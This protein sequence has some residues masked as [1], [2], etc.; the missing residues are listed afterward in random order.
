MKEN[1]P[2]LTISLLISDRMDTIP[3]CLDSLSSIMEAIPSELILIDTSKN[4]QV[5]Q[6]L[7]EYTDLVYEFEWCNDFAKARNEGL[8]RA[9]GEWFMFLDDD[10]WFINAT[11]LIKFFQSGEYR[12]YG[13]AKYQVRNFKDAEFIYYDDCRLARV[14]KIEGDSHFESKI[15][16]HFEP[17]RGMCKNL[18]ALVCH[19]GY[20][21][22]SIEE[23]RK[24][25]ERNRTLL[26]DMIKKEPNKIYWW[27]QLAQEYSYAGEYEELISFCKMCLQ[28]IAELDDPYINRQRGTFYIG[29]ITGYIRTQK[30]EEC[31]N[32]AEKALRD[33]K[34]ELVLKA[35]LLLKLAEGY[36][37]L[38]KCTEAKNAILSYLELARN[39]NLN[40]TD[41]VDQQAVFLVGEAFNQ[42]SKEIA[43][44]ILICCDLLQDDVSALERYYDE[45]GWSK[46]VAYTI[47]GIEKIMVEAIWTLPY[48][49]LFTRIII[50]VFSKSNLREAFRKEILNQSNAGLNEFQEIIY[51]LASTLQEVIIGPKTVDM[52][53]KNAL[54]QYVVAVYRW[55]DFIDANEC[56]Q[57]LNGVLPDYM[58][59][60]I[61]LNEYLELEVQDK[62]GALNKLKD[63]VEIFPDCAE[64]IGK[65]LEKYAEI[66]LYQREKEMAELRVQVIGQV[67][68]LIKNGQKNE[69]RN[70]LMQLN[71]MFPGD[72]EISILEKLCN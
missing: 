70:I 27:L 20:A 37:F 34:T 32:A 68:E 29:E 26:L 24:H 41:I 30:Y 50:D 3:R 4:P 47:G 2:Q 38:G 19:S 49:P 71:N 53:Y 28:N 69:A 46:T 17:V 21:Y 9:T 33:A 22:K 56:S 43:Y 40:D 7:L 66:E 35:M 64:G 18:E 44:A 72:E 57:W 10:E 39:V 67:K 31:V 62:I 59:A 45:L 55:Y 52:T 16:E 25:F 6:L 1:R 5:H 23:R 54:K 12:Q 13:Y 65:Y 15:H 61:C 14:F 8:K 63:V 11:P 48:T 60:A 36:L 58:E 51:W 42:N